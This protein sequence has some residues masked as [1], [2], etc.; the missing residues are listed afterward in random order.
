MRKSR[1]AQA[2]I[3]GVINKQEAGMLTT[4]VCRRHGLSAATFYE[5]KPK[6]HG[7]DMRTPNSSDCLFR[8][9][10]PIS[11]GCARS[12]RGCIF[13]MNNGGIGWSCTGFVRAFA[14]CLKFSPAFS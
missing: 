5:L 12:R 1:F 6:Y 8:F 14:P 3:I 4:E 7:M 11:P 9:G 10:T 13:V 2:Q